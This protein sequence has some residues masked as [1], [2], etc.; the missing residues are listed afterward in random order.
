MEWISVNDKLPEYDI[1]V[2]WIREDGLIFIADIDHDNDWYHFQEIYGNDCLGFDSSKMMEDTIEVK[3]THWMPL[4]KPP[5]T[6]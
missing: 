6:K 3:I 5:K 2:L 1:M 4:P